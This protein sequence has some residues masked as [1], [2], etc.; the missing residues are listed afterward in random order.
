[1][2]HDRAAN[3]ATD[4]VIWTTW[5]L[6]ALLIG[7]GAAFVT[8]TELHPIAEYRLALAAVGF[9]GLGTVLI[10]LSIERPLIRAFLYVVALMFVFSFALA[11]HEFA[12]LLLT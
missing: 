9:L 8:W 10:A 12:Q 11:P 3:D 4:Y 6:L 1:V 5:T 2:A 7:V